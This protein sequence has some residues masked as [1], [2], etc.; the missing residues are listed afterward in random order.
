MSATNGGDAYGAWQ[1][2]MRCKRRKYA[3]EHIRRAGGSWMYSSDPIVDNTLHWIKDGAFIECQS[4]GSLVQQSLNEHVVSKHEFKKTT[5]NCATCSKSAYYVPQPEDIPDVLRGLTR[6]IVIALRPVEL[7]CGTIVRGHRYGY[8][9]STK[10]VSLSWPLASVETRIDALADE[11]RRKARSAFAYL[12]EAQNSYYS[13]FVAEHREWLTTDGSGRYWGLNGLRR[14][15]VECALWPH[16]YWDSAMCEGSWLNDHTTQHRFKAGFK[17][18]L[19][20][21]V[22]DY[23]ADFELALYMHDRW[24]YETITGAVNS[25]DFESALQSLKAKPSM[26]TY[27]DRVKE[28]CA[29]LHRTLGPASLF[30]TIAPGEY[31]FLYSRL[32]EQAMT[33]CSR[34]HRGLACL[35]VHHIVHVAMQVL[36]GFITGVNVSKPVWKNFELSDKFDPS[37]RQV[38]TVV[39]R[40]EFQTGARARPEGKALDYHGRG[41]IHWHILIWL[42][43]VSRVCLPHMAAAHATP[44]D[45]DLSYFVNQVYTGGAPA[46]PLNDEPTSRIGSGKNERYKWHYPSHSMGKGVR[47]FFKRTMK[48]L[49]SHMDMDIVYSMGDVSKYMSKIG[50]YVSKDGSV[51]RH[52]LKETKGGWKAAQLVLQ[53]HRPLEPELYMNLL[54]CNLWWFH[55]DAKDVFPPTFESLSQ[56]VHF[57]AY[58]VS[59][60]KIYDE[61]FLDWFRRTRVD[62]E[63]PRPYRVQTTRAVAVKY[64]SYWKPDFWEQWVCMM[65]P[66]PGRVSAWKH[67][68]VDKMPLRLQSFFSCWQ[69]RPDVWG[70]RST[71]EQELSLLGC[72]KLELKNLLAAIGAMQLECTLILS[73]DIRIPDPAA[74]GSSETFLSKLNAQQTRIF[75]SICVKMQP[76]LEWDVE[77]AMSR[78]AAFILGYAGTGKSFVACASAEYCHQQD[79]KVAVF[80]WAAKQGV[81]MKSEI[82][83]VTT[84]TIYSAF[85][86]DADIA[87]AA[88]NL[89]Q[90]AL[91]LVDEVCS[92]HEEVFNRIMDVWTLASRLPTLVFMGDW[93]QLQPFDGNNEPCAGMSHSEYFPSLSVFH[94]TE[95]HRS[96]CPILVEFQNIVREGVPDNRA[97]RR[98]CRSRTVADEPSVES[99]ATVLLEHPE[100]TFIAIAKESVRILND[101]ACQALFHD[102]RP[103]GTAHVDDNEDIE[104]Y[105]GMR[106]MLTRNVDKAAGLVNG[107]MV[108]VREWNDSLMVS[109]PTQGDIMLPLRWEY[110]EQRQSCFF[111]VVPGYAFTLAKMQGE[112][113]ASHVLLA[114]CFACARCCIY[115]CDQSAD[116]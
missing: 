26:P 98:F 78:T 93:W 17:A 3:E 113:V 12:L 100:T 7:H 8:R 68:D 52:A 92:L 105:R 114:R 116:G 112:N 73:G 70:N 81:R 64:C 60:H 97:L 71:A 62:V 111:P 23:A 32:L 37:N 94:L 61:C 21:P 10:P 11:E 108:H 35:E 90:Y 44:Y 63:P 28:L 103:L 47:L 110:V 27:M 74:L 36:K 15:F 20:S 89:M 82:P 22:L 41:G 84:D 91:V 38:I 48:V 106:L 33:Q 40:G 42:K 19:L 80:T 83:Y 51:L 24:V 4:C 16:L 6:A 79:R 5:E 87:D 34:H 18:K 88:A 14:P 1:T 99:V 50:R 66:W 101:W 69:L 104:I 65:V 25:T 2:E 57:Q 29:D 58:T 102:A 31:N 75:Q 86:F 96:T 53:C 72:V 30:L 46:F 95:Q 109:T 13:Y 43:D 45:V 115:G 77:A 55:G 67:A 49:R 59:D 85:G 56:H 107:T 76:S 9:H 54:G 39:V